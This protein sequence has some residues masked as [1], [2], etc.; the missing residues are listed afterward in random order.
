VSYLWAIVLVK[1][2]L[3]AVCIKLLMSWH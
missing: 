2:F 3:L 1:L